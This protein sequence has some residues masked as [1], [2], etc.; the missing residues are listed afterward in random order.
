MADV[1]AAELAKAQ[2]K[3]DH[4]VSFEGKGLKLDDAS[5]AEDI[6]QAIELCP[7]MQ[8]LCLAGNTLGVEASQAI[9]SALQSRPTLKFALWKDLF[10]GRLRSEIPPSLR[11][12]SSAMI[13]A[14]TQLVELDL[15]DNAFGPDGAEAIRSLLT[16]P[17]A[18]TIQTLKFQN[19]GL[20]GGGVIIAE[21][22][23]AN[24]KKAEKEGKKLDL[25]TFIAGRNRL[26]NPGAKALSEA[27]SLIGTLEQIEVIQNGIQYEGF[28]AIADCIKYSPNLRILNLNDNIMTPRGAIAIAKALPCAKQLQVLNMGDC[29]VKSAGALSI[30]ENIKDLTSL[31][32]I[33]LSF[34]EITTEGGAAIAAA[35]ASLP[36]VKTLNLDGN[37]FGDDGKKA[38]EGALGMDRLSILT[39]LNE[40][41]GVP[42]DGEEEGEPEQEEEEEKKDKTPEKAVPSSTPFVFGA[43]APAL[44]GGDDT[45]RN[46]G[47]GLST[48]GFTFSAISAGTNV[49]AN[50]GDTKTVFE[51]S[52]TAL[53]SAPA[54]NDNPE[55]E[56]QATFEPLVHLEKVESKTGEEDEEELYKHR[57]KVFRFDKDV[58][59]WKEKGV[60]DI[61][62][63][64]NNNTG[65]ARI[66]MRRDI[67]LK[68]CCNHTITSNMEMKPNAGSDKSLVWCTHADFSEEEPRPEQLAV[69]FKTADI[70]SDFLKVFNDTRDALPEPG[71]TPVKETVKEAAKETV[72]APTKTE[73]QPISFANLATPPKPAVSSPS[74]TES[75][76]YEPDVHFEPLVHLTEIGKGTSGEEGEEEMFCARSKLYRFNKDTSEWKER[77]LGDIK[78]T[79]NRSS[80]KGRILMRREQILKICC[81]HYITAE[82]ELKP[83]Q[84]NE[85]FLVWHTYADFADEEAKFEQLAARF[86][87]AELAGEFKEAFEKCQARLGDTS[88]VAEDEEEEEVEEKQSTE[89]GAAAMAAFLA[90]QKSNWTCGTCYLSNISAA[91]VCIACQTANP[92][93]APPAP[94]DSNKSSATPGGFTFGA[95]PLAPGASPL[96]GAKPASDTFASPAPFSFGAP[97]STAFD[98]GATAVPKATPTFGS[99]APAAT[100]GSPAPAP[101]ATFGGFTF[102]GSVPNITPVSPA[103]PEEEKKPAP[104]AGF[105]FGTPK[106]NGS[107]TP[108]AVTQTVAIDYTTFVTAPTEAML[109]VAD[110][111]KVVT[112]IDTSDPV[113]VARFIAKLSRVSSNSTANNTQQIMDRLLKKSFDRQE[114]VSRLPNELLVAMGLIKSEEKRYKPDVDMSSMLRLLRHAV[115][116]PYFPKTSA[117]IVATF[118]KRES[119][120]LSNHVSDCSELLA[121]CKI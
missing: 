34:N 119:P 65:K 14:G 79:F 107:P 3:E 89:S 25:R 83:H 72:P 78:I 49:F 35:A 7:N 56:C 66:I 102:G 75:V 37:H 10:T 77:G 6:L 30:A 26:E 28:V 55:Q 85:K 106:S 84:G 19:N 63:L 82:M 115:T 36:S 16:S 101:A 53:F 110:A 62:I 50:K 40:D 108:A 96:F 31:K 23:K 39:G 32:E 67:I 116:Q 95:K 104:F 59:A 70:C 5:T 48:G 97:K 91:N 51:G 52:G 22:I 8:T 60:G 81:N 47:A 109:K 71:S 15:S 18:Y 46:F 12:L 61:R 9:S 43:T 112:A 13:I 93:N 42:S 45:N 117:A 17:V 33:I 29:L 100:F 121:A 1:L 24:H 105:S 57:A 76:E 38:V 74:K 27:F 88:C 103:K 41:E 58:N 4:I 86:K 94:V 114:S 80:G 98:F 54:S 64:K 68:L 118:I 44:V 99:P 87:T 90:K 92:A 2:V 69:R 73:P 113:F 20:G 11:A 111:D 120:V 21:C